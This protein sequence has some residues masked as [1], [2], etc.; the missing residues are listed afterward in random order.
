M[1]DAASFY[2]VSYI[3]RFLLLSTLSVHA[4]LMS[5]LF[6]QW[7]RRQ[8]QDIPISGYGYMICKINRNSEKL[9]TFHHQ[10]VNESPRCNVSHMQRYLVPTFRSLYSQGCR[11]EI[12][13]I[14]SDLHKRYKS[15]VRERLAT[16]LRLLR[17]SVYTGDK[18]PFRG[19]KI[20]F[21]DSR[22][23]VVGPRWS[24]PRR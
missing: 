21:A 14:C 6:P 15:I 13:V 18:V 10:P 16:Q 4:V 23:R 24:E 3:N 11:S 22:P 17:T 2:L 19:L 7:D 5:D 9:M 12:T 8:L 20:E 1:T